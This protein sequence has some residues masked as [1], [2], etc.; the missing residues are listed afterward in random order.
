MQG[1]FTVGYETDEK[2]GTR[3]GLDICLVSPSGAVT[4]GPAIS[5]DVPEGQVE[6][7]AEIDKVQATIRALFPHFDRQFQR[8]LRTLHDL[9]Q[10][11]LT[12]QQALSSVSNSALKNLKNEIVTCEA[13]RV[14]TRHLKSLGKWALIFGLATT[15]L[16]M[17]LRT[18]EHS[19]GPYVDYVL[20]SQ[21]AFAWTGA[22]AGA[23]V[24]FASRKQEMGF[25]DLIK[26]EREAIWFIIRLAYTGVQTMIIGLACVL[27]FIQVSIGTRT[28]QQFTFVVEVAVFVG[29]LC[30]FSE[31][32]L[33]TAIAKQASTLLG[34]TEP[35]LAS[36]APAI[37]VTQ[38]QR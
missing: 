1:A 4:C 25:E 26:V 13:S 9:A 14:K 8:Y 3:T 17:F 38:P 30:G 16:A 35:P 12:G 18:R 34:V 6:L 7:K 33:S 37:A 31:Q 36:P 19:S 11:G 29:L 32:L 10:A 24:S 27:G 22:M 21:F 28:T 2:T 20:L 23:F 5:A 15:L